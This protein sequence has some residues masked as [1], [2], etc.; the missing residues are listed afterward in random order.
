MN[1][2]PNCPHRPDHVCQDCWNAARDNR[3]DQV[4]EVIGK[5]WLIPRDEFALTHAASESRKEG[6][7]TTYI[8]FVR[9]DSR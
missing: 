1:E 4:I 7:V 3:L 2:R 9:K 8:S 6:V 5:F